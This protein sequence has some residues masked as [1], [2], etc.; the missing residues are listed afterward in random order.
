MSKAWADTRNWFLQRSLIATDNNESSL[1]TTLLMV[2]A[3][4]CALGVIMV[5]SS[6]VMMAEDTIGDSKY[7][8]NKQLLAVSIGLCA[9][10][11]IY[12]I[13]TVWWHRMAM[14][15]LIVVAIL[16]LMLFIP[17][18]GKEVNSSTRWLPLGILNLQVSEV[19]KLAAFIYMASYL[20]RHGDTARQTLS[21]FI[22]PLLLFA[23]FGGL[24][25]MQPDMG[26]TV[27][28]FAT[29]MAM[30]FIGGVRIWQFSIISIVLVAGAVAL[31][32]SSDYRLK[33]ITSFLNPWA[34]PLN[35]GFQLIQSLIAVGSGNWFGLGLGNSVQKLLFLPEPHTDF[36]FSVLAEELGFIGVSV[37]VLLFVVFIWRA[38]SIA[39]MAEKLG[40]TF[41]AHLAGGIGFW[42]GIQAFV[43]MG[44]DMGVFPTKGLTLPF[45]S[46]GGSSMLVTCIAVALLLRIA[47][48]N[49]L[50]SPK[51][52]RGHARK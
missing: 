2:V 32:F 5:A 17:G 22:K 1:D 19:A 38:F 43:H 23:V 45:V 48:E 46:Y 33:R 18:V 21:G 36:I 9:G 16:L 39:V 13:N 15:M 34:D 37:V 25:L 49:H 50:A 28:L 6:S 52:R 4:L 3:L 27:V 51:T 44:V 40:N 24:I 26:T 31:S 12:Q 7:Y 8:L 30:L 35:D 20:T 10:L 11:V 41:G 47:R 29:G 42:I 14:P